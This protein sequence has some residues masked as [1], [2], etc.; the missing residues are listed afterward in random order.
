[1]IKI[2]KEGQSGSNLESLGYIKR[3]GLVGRIILPITRYLRAINTEKYM[4][5]AERHLDIG[6]GD[7][8]FLRRSKCEERYGLDKLLGD[9]V[10]DKL[11]FS[12][13]YFDYITMLAVIEHLSRP[14]DIFKEVCRVLKTGGRFII[15][16]PR[17]SAEFLIKIYAKN[18][19]EEHESYFDYDRIKKLAGTMFDIT[20]HHTFIFGM[21]QAF[22][23]E[24]RP[25]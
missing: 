18:I 14:E 23:L 11:D 19:D 1:M 7:G 4:M 16:T 25:S 2:T 21:N 24:K 12:D 22:C 8:Y 20:G 9:E 17:K 6:C 13:S 5:P 10:T 15:T 3:R